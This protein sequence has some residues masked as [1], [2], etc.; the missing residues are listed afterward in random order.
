MLNARSA[1]SQHLPFGIGTDSYPMTS[2]PMDRAVPATDLTAASSDSQ[3][4]S[5]SFVFAISSTCF[6]VT[7]PTLFLFGSADP[8]A[9][10]AARFNRID[11]EAK[12]ELDGLVELRVLHLLH[13]GDRLFDR[14]RPIGYRLLGGGE[15]L[16]ARH[17]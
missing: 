13:Q 2:M 8:L 5:G 3:L 10:F 6:L 14:V 15:F 4:R 17:C 7:V 11:A 16:S 9:R 12:R 1:G